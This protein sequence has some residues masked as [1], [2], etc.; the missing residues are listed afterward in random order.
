MSI[1]WG[2]LHIRDI[3]L[4]LSAEGGGYAGPFRRLV[5]WGCCSFYG[6]LGAVPEMT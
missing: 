4:N 5:S 3:G 1:L 2:L 6:L